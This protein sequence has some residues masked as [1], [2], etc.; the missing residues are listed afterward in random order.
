MCRLETNNCRA[1]LSFG[2]GF[3]AA[4]KLSVRAVARAGFRVKYYLMREAPNIKHCRYNLKVTF[5]TLP[6]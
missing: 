5:T 4:L 6:I 2:P 3:V 1:G